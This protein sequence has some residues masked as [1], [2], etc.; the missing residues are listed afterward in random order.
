VEQ[1]QARAGGIAA[2]LRQARAGR[3]HACAP[4]RERRRADPGPGGRD[5]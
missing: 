4:G 5:R 3:Q 1:L 2:G